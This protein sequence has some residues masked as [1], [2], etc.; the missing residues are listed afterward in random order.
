LFFARVADVRE[1]LW[2]DGFAIGFAARQTVF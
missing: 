1:R 2:L